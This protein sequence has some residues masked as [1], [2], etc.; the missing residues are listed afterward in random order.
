M[1]CKEIQF[2]TNVNCGG[3]VASLRLHLD[4]A[5]GIRKWNVGTANKGKVLSVESERITE[6]QVLD[7]V[8]KASFN[9]ELIITSRLRTNTNC[10]INIVRKHL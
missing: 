8:K 1:T 10:K 5:E 3:C 2:R 7:I 9:V 6:E 4:N